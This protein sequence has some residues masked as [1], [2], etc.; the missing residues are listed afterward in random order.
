MFELDP[1]ALNRTLNILDFFHYVTQIQIDRG[2]NISFLVYMKD[3]SFFNYNRFRSQLMG[4]SLME[5]KPETINVILVDLYRRAIRNRILFFDFLE[6]VSDKTVNEK[7]FCEIEISAWV[8]SEPWCPAL[9][10]IENGRP[11]DEPKVENMICHRI[12]FTEF[13]IYFNEIIKLLDNEI[14]KSE[15]SDRNVGKRATNLQPTSENFIDEQTDDLKISEKSFPRYLIFNDYQTQKLVADFLQPF[16]MDTKGIGTAC[17]LN[18][19]KRVHRI[20]YK[21]VSAE[22]FYNSLKE[23]YGLHCSNKGILKFD[24]IDFWLKAK[25]KEKIEPIIIA[26]NNF[27]SEKNI[28]R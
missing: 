3:S 1:D 7:A 9:L 12:E 22:K 27:L 19:L 10:D 13:I 8:I 6:K 25:N 4:L 5:K 11:K 21:H 16:F 18:A 14:N 17:V 24:N 15:I 26:I 28:T 20:Q 2:K 23:Y